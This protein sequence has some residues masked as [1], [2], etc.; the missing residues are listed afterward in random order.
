MG[1]IDVLYQHHT[2]CTKYLASG[3]AGAPSLPSM[4]NVDTNAVV[5]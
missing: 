1:Q 2:L 5:I 4:S 3:V